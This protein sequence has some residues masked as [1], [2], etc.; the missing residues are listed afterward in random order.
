MSIKRITIENIKGIEKE[1]FDLDIIPNMPSLLVAPNGFGKSSFAA[2]FSSLRTNKIS[3]HESHCH[4]GDTTR[5]PS[6][7]VEYEDASGT[8]HSLRADAGVNEIGQHFDVFVV[9]NQIHAKGTRRTF[10]GHTNVS[11]A[12]SIQPVVL[13]DTVP[14]KVQFGYSWTAQKALCGTNGKILPSLT[15][16]L[17]NTPVVAKLSGMYETLD[18]AIRPTAQAT[19]QAFRMALGSQSGTAAQLRAWMANNSLGGLDT[20]EPLKDVAEVLSSTGSCSAG[21]EAYLAA[22][23]IVELYKQDKA[24]F[25][26]ACKYSNYQLEREEY[27]TDLAAFNTTWCDICPRERDGALI[28]EFPPAHHISNGQRDVL[29]FIALLHRARRKLSKDNAILIIDEVFDYLDDANL[30]AAQYYVT[31]FIDTFRS[32]GRRIYPLILTHLNP[33][34]FRNYAFSKQKVYFLDKRSIKPNASFLKLLQFRADPKTLKQAKDDVSRYLLH[35]HPS[36]TSRREDFKVY[37]LK[38]TWGEPSIF[39]QFVESEIEKYRNDQTDYDPLAVC[40][41]VRR[42]IEKLAYD[43]LRPEHRPGFLDTHKTKEKLEYAEGIGSSVPE[44]Y[45]LLG[46]VYNAGLHWKNNQDIISPIAAKLENVTIAHMIK[47][48][49]HVEVAGSDKTQQPPSIPGPSGCQLTIDY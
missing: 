13:V 4:R 30:V 31:Q 17:A 19:V 16:L 32:K 43:E 21:P 39:D 11:A 2:A 14:P 45:Y 49:W 15:D 28:V 33:I 40:C 44:Y 20:L 1:R 3:L 22:L 46:L 36:T 5:L 23:Q 29:S 42:R 48:L 25:K 35:Y 10:G 8:P 41:A 37:G 24:V 18:R 47:R 9:N 38:E 7:I 6:L 26:K 34:W 12:M 27:T